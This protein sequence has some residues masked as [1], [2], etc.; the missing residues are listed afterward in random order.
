VLVRWNSNKAWQDAITN[1]KQQKRGCSAIEGN[2]SKK[3]CCLPWE[4]GSMGRLLHLSSSSKL[5]LV[6][7]GLIYF[8]FCLVELGKIFL[9]GSAT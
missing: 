9:A 5:C 7:Y 4:G 3:M 2:H 8:V 6:H 1:S